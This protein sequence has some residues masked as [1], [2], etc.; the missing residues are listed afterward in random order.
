MS[1]KCAFA[2]TRKREMYAYSAALQRYRKLRNFSHAA[3]FKA[4]HS[5]EAFQHLK[6]V[7]K[8]KIFARDQQ[9]NKLIARDQLMLRVTTLGLAR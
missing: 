5:D 4:C 8:D 2:P 6:R 7:W 9:V 3:C 1:A